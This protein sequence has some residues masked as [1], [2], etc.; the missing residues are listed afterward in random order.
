M[1]TDHQA[2]VRHDTLVDQI[3]DI[4]KLGTV[5]YGPGTS[6]LESAEDEQA[7]YEE[8]SKLS[9]EVGL[10]SVYRLRAEKIIKLVEH[11]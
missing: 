3:V 2:M 11:S 8:G 6:H 4:L 10:N 7:A 1:S 5:I 9:F